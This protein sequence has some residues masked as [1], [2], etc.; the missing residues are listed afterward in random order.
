MNSKVYILIVIVALGAIYLLVPREQFHKSDAETIEEGVEL[1]REQNKLI[2]LYINADWCTYC[3]LIE[4][5]FGESEEFQQIM[6]E[7]Y[8]WVTLDFNENPA[9]VSRFNLQGPP[10]MI[11]LKQNGEALVGIPGYPP[12]GVLD[13]IAMLK[14]ASK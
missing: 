1:A 14:E 4:K 6:D 11:V 13:V 5:E 9:L 8:I 10:A 7:H 12:N 3:R 2:F